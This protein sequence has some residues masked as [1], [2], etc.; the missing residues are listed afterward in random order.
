MA[1]G[2][3]SRVAFR[4]DD[5]AAVTDA[6]RHVFGM[7]LETHDRA[8]PVMGLR[9]TVGQDGFE[10]VQ[11]LDER[12][13][14]I[15]TGEGATLGALVLEVDDLEEAHRRLIEAGATLKSSI[16]TDTGLREISYG[17][18]FHGIPLVLVQKDETHLLTTPPTGPFE[19]VTES[20]TVPPQR[21]VV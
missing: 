14:E 9:A 19:C 21:A 18:S 3:V 4:V 5:I 8:V 13:D 15:V 1:F 7:E 6:F 11:G 10:L 20:P 16:V 12:G 2:Q 17:T